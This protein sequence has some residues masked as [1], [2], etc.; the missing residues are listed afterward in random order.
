MEVQKTQSCTA[1]CCG[2]NLIQ[3]SDETRIKL[4]PEPSNVCTIGCCS[5]TTNIIEEQS[6]AQ[7]EVQVDDKD[8]CCGGEEENENEVD[9]PQID[10]E[11]L[12]KYSPISFSIKG[13]TCTG[14]INKL[15]RVVKKINGMTQLNA[16][17]LLAQGAARYDTEMWTSDALLKLISERTGFS[18]KLILSAGT[19]SLV[20]FVADVPLCVS[21]ARK[22]AGVL[23]ISKLG[24][25]KIR[26]S[27]DPAVVSPRKLLAQF[28]PFKGRLDLDYNEEGQ[29][30]KASSTHVRELFLTTLLATILTIPVLI[31]A[32]APL[33]PRPL[34]YG[35]VSLILTTIVQLFC[36]YK[37]YRGAFKSL[38][39]NHELDL[40]SVVVLSTSSAWI[41]SIV[42]FAFETRGVHISQSFFETSSLLVTFILI[43]RLV[44]SW[45]RLKAMR[46]VTSR[47][48]KSSNDAWILSSEDP[49]ENFDLPT[50]VPAC[51][52]HYGDV[53][54]VNPDTLIVTDG[55]IVEGSSE[56]NESILTGESRPITKIKGSQV[57]GGTSNGSGALKVKV[58]CNISESAMSTISN[59]VQN[60]SSTQIKMQDLADKI[61]RYFVPLIIIITTIVLIVWI[62][63]G[64]V[65]RNQPGGTA[66]ITALKY[67][68]TVLAVSCPCAI[69]LAIPMVIVVASEVAAKEGLIF[70]SAQSLDTLRK[71]T[72]VFLDKTGTL[73]KGELS[74]VHANILSSTRAETLKTCYSLTKDSNHPIA[75]SVREYVRNQLNEMGET[76]LE[77]SE[78]DLIKQIPGQGMEGELNGKA[79]R[80]GN[81]SW[82]G[83]VTEHPEVVQVLKVGNSIFCVSIDST[84]VAVFGLEDT[85][86]PEAIHVVEKLQKQGKVVGIIS[87]DHK[88]V[89]K[90]VAVQLGIPLNLSF[91]N[92]YPEMKKTHIERMQEEGAVVLFSGDGMNDAVALAQADVGISMSPEASAIASSAA[93][94]SI[95]RNDLNCILIALE[96]SQA[97]FRR[98]IINFAWSFVY[99]VFAILLAAGAL[100]PLVL[101]PQYAGI[102][103]IIS[104]V[105]IILVALQLK[106][107]GFHQEEKEIFELEEIPNSKSI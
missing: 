80:G 72:H 63:V 26:V 71:C 58:T 87:G 34:A 12:Q 42:A 92:C 75:K 102:A 107:V 22:F 93:Q 83:D 65:G 10:R 104:V 16:S 81:P 15:E 11:A 30:L 4:Q 13:M 64:V 48:N 59:L 67:A 8:S 37:I 23:E 55:V 99:N 91:G 79:I 2:G 7:V 85:I 73:T 27:F 46:A 88:N 51:L 35:I 36:G 53:I 50:L 6:C 100:G 32:W 60:T 29:S 17:L 68:I 54:S 40:D 3:T 39:Y 44:T 106:I 56:I 24:K 70:K 86:K 45:V 62:I 33:P 105:P 19:S 31:L 97:A 96:L 94:L 69:G 57:F 82:S 43:G 76:S 38:V 14:C 20:L 78:L 18:C 98:I 9:V 49:D 95:L 47:T 28:E 74:V 21:S 103:E 90:K 61:A 77:D 41:F 84:L 25:K 1:G 101:Q 52:L 5:T 89:V 66:F